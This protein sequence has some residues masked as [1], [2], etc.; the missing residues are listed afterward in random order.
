[1]NLLPMER[2][3]AHEREDG[4]DFGLLLPLVSATD[5]NRVSVKLIHEHDQF[6][7]DIPALE[8][9]L[10]HSVDA[11][12]GDH[13]SGRVDLAQV[14]LPHPASAWGTSGRYLYRYV[15]HPPGGAPP[16]DWVIDPFARE[17]GVGKLSAITLGYRDHVWSA[18]GLPSGPRRHLP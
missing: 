16:L 10:T 13:W 2:L 1:M 15:V 5:G 7:Q 18:P 11:D 12:Y 14:S 6:L 4:F 8:F 17:F 3:G 9:P